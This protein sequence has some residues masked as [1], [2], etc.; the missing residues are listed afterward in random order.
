VPLDRKSQDRKINSH[1]LRLIDICRNNNM[2]I[3]NGR[4]GNDQ[5]GAFTFKH[6]SVID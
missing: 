2:F 5:N 3:L 6:K 1:G 4:I